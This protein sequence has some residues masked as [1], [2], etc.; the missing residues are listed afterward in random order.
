MIENLQQHYRRLYELHGPTEKAVQW[1]DRNSQYARFAVLREI[2]DN[3]G[4]VL[5]IGCGLGDLLASLREAGW[6]LPYLGIDIVPEFIDLASG[7]YESDCQSMFRVNEDLS[8][9]E[10]GAYDYVMMSGLFNNK[11]A[12]NWSFLMD[13]LKE[14][15]RISSKGIAFNA[16]SSFVDYQDEG[17]FYYNPTKVLEFCKTVLRGHPV[18]RHD[19]VLK[20]GGF[21]FEFAVYVYKGCSVR[22]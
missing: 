10:D 14:A 18:L 7:R 11:L 2:S 16:M 9:I 13:T 4:S 17:L 19:Y 3:P 12:N 6:Q 1:S 20:E 15:Y 22:S 8:A 21:P 5:D